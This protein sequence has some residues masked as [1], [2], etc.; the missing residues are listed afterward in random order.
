MSNLTWIT[1]V[2]LGQDSHRF[3][4]DPSNKPCILAGV[5]FENL[6]GLQANSDG[7]VVFHAICNALSSLTHQLILG[8]TADDMLKSQ[9]I[10]DSA[11][12]L[13][14]AVR[15]LA[16]HQRIMHVAISLECS[17]PKIVPY[18]SWM[19]Q[20]IANILKISMDQVGITATSGEGLSNYGRGLGIQCFCTITLLE[21]V[22]LS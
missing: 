11:L 5:V 21:Q 1:K 4:T 20:N 19:R 10:T 18:L 7:D 16:P 8:G 13:E 15:S 22:H 12:Y 3:L 9:G 6:P 14:E 17:R 2:G